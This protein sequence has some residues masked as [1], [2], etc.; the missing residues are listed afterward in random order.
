[1]ENTTF[2]VKRILP[3]LFGFFIMGF[4]DVV[5]IST[6]YMKASFNLSESMA[7][8]IPTMVFFWFLLLSV[9][10]A[11]HPALLSPS[12]NL[13]ALAVI[14]DD[15][16]E[17]KRSWQLC[18]TIRQSNPDGWVG[19]KLMIYLAKDSLSA[20]L[21]CGDRIVFMATPEP[22]K[23]PPD[24]ARFNY[25]RWLRVKGICASAYV[26]K[27]AWRFVAPPSRWD[28]KARASRIRSMLVAAFR[29][30]GLSGDGLAL[31]SAMSFGARDELSKELKN[32]FAVTGITHILSVSGLHGE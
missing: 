7:G 21:R 26:R 16:V 10:T 11:M 28:L 2:P 25:A 31:V 19:K 17:K 30:S 29:Q 15:P 24:T 13:R 22:L 12:F 27:S 8:F 4:C 6:T 32:E 14:D 1:M 18:L 9:P 20:T 3:V 23:Q 5:G